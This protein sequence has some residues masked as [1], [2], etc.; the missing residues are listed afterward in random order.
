MACQVARG[1]GGGAA[2]MEGPGGGRLRG[3][4]ESG[5]QPSQPEGGQGMVAVSSAVVAG[6]ATLSQELWCLHRS[7][8]PPKGESSLRSLS[9]LTQRG[10][11]RTC[12]GH[13]KGEWGKK[14]RNQT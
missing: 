8:R 9:Y 2:T 1:R 5:S 6:G 10:T 13:L 3:P 11:G 12:K 4:A 7:G 14:E